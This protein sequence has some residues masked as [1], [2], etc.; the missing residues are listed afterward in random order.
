MENKK[1][2]PFLGILMLLPSLIVTVM[3]ILMCMVGH[4]TVIL[5]VFYYKLTVLATLAFI[6][7]FI[8]SMIKRK[9]VWRKAVLY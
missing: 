6:I 9:N 5:F 2:N 7:L 3:I 4:L 8:I 1:I